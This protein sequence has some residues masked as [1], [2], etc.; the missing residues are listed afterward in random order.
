VSEKACPIFLVGIYYTFLWGLGKVGFEQYPSLKS[1]TNTQ[2]NVCS[3]LIT[4][5]KQ[6]VFATYA[7]GIDK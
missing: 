7:L 1:E 4:L 2:L 3:K 6:L 5:Y